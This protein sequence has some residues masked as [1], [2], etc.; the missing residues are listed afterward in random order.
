MKPYRLTYL[1]LGI[2]FV[3]VGISFASRKATLQTEKQK[4]ESARKDALQRQAELRS[5]YPTVDFNETETTDVNKREI[6]RQRKLQHNNRGMV[7]DIPSPKD[8]EVAS[9]S[10]N[11]FDF[12]ALPF[13]KSEVAILGAVLSAEAHMSQDKQA[14]YSEFE[15]QILEVFKANDVKLI[16]GQLWTVERE[17]GIVK[18]PNGQQ[19]LY[20]RTNNGM[21]KVGE[22]YVLFLQRV[23]NADFYR[24][25]TG[26]QCSLTGVTPLDYSPQFEVYRGFDEPSFL[27]TVRSSTS[28]QQQPKD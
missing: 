26:Y 2:A 17:G 25:L 24:V 10:H 20:R 14:V 3:M 7:S 12:P 8:R 4:A 28:T 16:A 15:V 13:E 23:P 11:Q 18:Y 22:R 9:Y 27:K 5:T 1:L 6:Q 19:I 21:L